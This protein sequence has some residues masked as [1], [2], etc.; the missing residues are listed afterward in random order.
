MEFQEELDHRMKVDNI[1]NELFDGQNSEDTLPV[2]NFDCLR[3]LMDTYSQHCG[4]WSDY[5]LKHV[6][7]LSNHCETADSFDVYKVSQKN[8]GYLPMSTFF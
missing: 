1:F 8:S 3:F 4:N 2:H 5:S 6:R 7:Y